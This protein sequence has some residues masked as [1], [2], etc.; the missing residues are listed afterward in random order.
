MVTHIASNQT[1][2]TSHNFRRKSVSHM[3]SLTPPFPTTAMHCTLR[4]QDISIKAQAKR[5]LIA[6]KLES[7]KKEKMSSLLI[8]DCLVTRCKLKFPCIKSRDDHLKNQHNYNDSAETEYE[9]DE[10]LDHKDIEHGNRWFL[11]KWV[12]NNDWSWE[13]RSNLHNCKLLVDSYER[14]E[15]IL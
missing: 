9:V 5:R 13:P 2:V 14:T 3:K 12:G 11:V 1:C 10:I 8:Y 4:R 7:R 6:F 15:M